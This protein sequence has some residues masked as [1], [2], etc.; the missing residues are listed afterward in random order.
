MGRTKKVGIAGRFGPRYGST[1]R[2]KYKRV[3]ERLHAPH[4]CP[5]CGSYK[6][7]RLSVGIWYC[8]K[9]GFKFAGGAYEP[10]T[11]L[12]KTITKSS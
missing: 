7:R 3:M 6:V 1:V 4:K 9:C 10:K 2:K 11:R 5:N 8:R 12:V